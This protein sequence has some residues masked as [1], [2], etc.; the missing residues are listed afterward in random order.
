MPVGVNR[1]HIDFHIKTQ[2]EPIDFDLEIFDGMSWED[3]NKIFVVDN[4]AKLNV[5]V[6][7]AKDSYLSDGA[8][9]NFE[10]ITM[11]K[12]NELYVATSL[13]NPN[14]TITHDLF[15]YPYV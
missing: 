4:E 11:Y 14:N 2:T 9:G 5:L 8:E 13:I 12:W 3:A 7:T 10:D 15:F 6:K 1:I